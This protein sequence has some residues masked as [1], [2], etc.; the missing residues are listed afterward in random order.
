MLLPMPADGLNQRNGSTLIV[1]SALYTGLTR[2][3]R[4][5]LGDDHLRIVDNS[6]LVLIVGNRF[7]MDRGTTNGISGT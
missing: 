2:G 4:A 3:E 7:G 6:R 5:R 1:H